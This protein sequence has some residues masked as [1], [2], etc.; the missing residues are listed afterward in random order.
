MVDTVGKRLRSARLEQEITVEQAAFAT[1]VRPERIVDLENDDYTN[2]PSMT[3]AKGFLLIYARYL[4]VDVSDF[5]G[6]WE[7]ANP[8][9]LEDYEYLSNAPERRSAPVVH[10]PSRPIWP[11]VIVLLL[12]GAAALSGY[13]LMTLKRLGAA[14]EPPPKRIE[15]EDQA[16]LRGPAHMVSPAM[17]GMPEQP[18]P[19]ASPT[20]SASP[21]PADLSPAPDP[22]TAASPEPGATPV[23]PSA[24]APA[25]AQPGSTPSVKSITLRPLKKTW[26]KVRQDVPDS[27][28]VFEDWL[29]P[30]ARALTFTGTRFW[31]EYADKN[32]IE[33]LQE[34]VPVRSE[35]AVLTIQ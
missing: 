21:T 10:A 29:Y 14:V 4:A 26:V 33:V 1:K 28:P 15:N 22:A 27:P 20:P 17:E 13:F 11:F 31:I 9:S 19:A 32:G 5:V 6:G 30:D 25:P 24:P 12:L 8:V 18:A 16:Y 3:Y 34:G 35:S 23:E 2:F 7:N